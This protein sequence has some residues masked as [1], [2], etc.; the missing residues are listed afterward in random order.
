M[1]IRCLAGRHAA[2]PGAI[3]NQGFEFGRCGRCGRDM[4]RS[5][6]RW[7]LVPKGFRVVWKR[8]PGRQAE[9]SAMQLLLNLPSTGRALIPA[10]DRRRSGPSE[11]VVLAVLGL[12]YLAWTAGERLRGW[13]QSLF[14]ARARSSVIHLAPYAPAGAEVP[15]R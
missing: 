8:T 15:A 14:P 6:S 2:A 12:R 10:P 9:V 1:R 11:M 13:R 5:G 7:R 3:R 4:V